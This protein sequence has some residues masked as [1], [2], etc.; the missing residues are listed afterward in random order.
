MNAGDLL[1]LLGILAIVCGAFVV[2]GL[3]SGEQW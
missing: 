1:S 2:G 3:L